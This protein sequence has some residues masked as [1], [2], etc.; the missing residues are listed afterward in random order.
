MNR[1]VSSGL[2]DRMTIGTDSPF[3]TGI[4]RQS[5]SPGE[6]GWIS[7]KGRRLEGRFVSGAR[8]ADKPKHIQ[9]GCAIRLVRAGG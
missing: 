7:K 2:C 5:M 9:N 8:I 6:S 4:Q 3:M 1:Q